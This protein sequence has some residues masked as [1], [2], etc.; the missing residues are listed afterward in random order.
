MGSFK[1]AQYEDLIGKCIKSIDK[2]TEFRAIFNL[3]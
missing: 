1:V 3:H 2:V